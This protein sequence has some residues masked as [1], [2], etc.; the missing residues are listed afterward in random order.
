MPIN[1]SNF[2]ESNFSGAQGVQGLQGSQGIQGVQGL[3]NQGT[4]GLQGTQGRQGTQGLSNQGSQG[5][6]GSQGIQGLQGLSNQGLQGLSNQ[7]TQGLQGTQGRQGTQ[8]LSN[9]GV[10]G[11]QGTQGTVLSGIPQNSQ[12]ANYTLQSSDSGDHISITTGG[13]NIPASVFS[14]GDT[15]TIFNNSSS[16]QTITQNANVT[17]RFAGTTSTGN[18]TLAGYGICSVLCIVGGATPTFVISGAGLT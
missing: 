16:S 4:Q 9:Q 18:R 11:L 6:Q 5:L 1:L 10:Q 14:P 12:T 13:V 8:G 15:V 2:L 3:S 7:G 17:L